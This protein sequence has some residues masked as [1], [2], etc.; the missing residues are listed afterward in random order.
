MLSTN[1]KWACEAPNRF[2]P[3]NVIYYYSEIMHETIFA[4]LALCAV[5]SPVTGEFPSQSRVTRSVDVFFGMNKRLSQQSLGWWCETPTR[6]LWR[7]CNGSGVAPGRQL[8]NM[9]VNQ[10]IKYIRLHDQKC[11][12]EAIIACLA[13]MSLLCFRHLQKSLSR[14][15]FVK[16]RNM[17]IQGNVFEKFVKLRP[18][19]IKTN[20]V[21]AFGSEKISQCMQRFSTIRIVNVKITTVDTSSK[22][23]AYSNKTIFYPLQSN[24]DNLQCTGVTINYG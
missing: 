16:I 5:N 23:I 1:S 10:Q 22:L 6:S 18:F 4:L 14:Y 24:G 21:I 17:C 19:C 12:F 9:K 13:C 8:S 15:I 7:H 11:F 3:I 2:T 20:K